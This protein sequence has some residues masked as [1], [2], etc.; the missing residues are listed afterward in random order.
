MKTMNFLKT[1]MIA[2]MA[3][4]MTTN[5]ANAASEMT[6]TTAGTDTKSTFLVNAGTTEKVKANSTDSYEYRIYAKEEAY[7][8][9]SG[10]GDTDL[11]LFIYDENGNL[12]DSD[13]DEGDTCL[14]TFTPKWTGKFTIKVK[15]LGGVYNKYT[16][17]I[18]Q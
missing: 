9:V 8:W 4:V 16:I 6:E 14:C 11:D 18:V 3:M 12:I 1:A 15:N 5:A 13:T 10:D 2:M 17:R 7:V